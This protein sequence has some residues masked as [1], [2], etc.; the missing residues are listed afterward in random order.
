MAGVI[1][2]IWSASA[3]ADLQAIHA[4]IAR[5]SRTYAR[6]TI[7]RIIKAT[8]RLRR[9]PTSGARVAE[10][11]RDDIREI[12]AGSYRIIYRLQPTQLS[13]VTVIHAARQLPDSA[14]PQ[15]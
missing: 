8:E 9:F 12:I 1:R 2:I 4:F 11:D 6:R 3:R 7:D 14:K 13:I 5:D 10:W 15:R